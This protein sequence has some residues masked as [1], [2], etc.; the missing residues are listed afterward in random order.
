MTLHGNF[1]KP[2]AFRHCVIVSK[3]HFKLPISAPFSPTP[4]LPDH[5]LPPPHR[6]LPE[7]FLCSSSHSSHATLPPSLLSSLRL[8]VGRFRSSLSVRT[9]YAPLVFGYPH[10]TRADTLP[11]RSNPCSLSYEIAKCF[12][13]QL[14][15]DTSYLVYDLS[16]QKQNCVIRS[17]KKN[18]RWIQ[19]LNGRG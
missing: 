7:F 5:P 17:W 10:A 13:S 14:R 11:P 4:F 3:T 18:Q 8:T 6:R 15:Y 9:E 12:P 16:S 19:C 1:T 2:Q